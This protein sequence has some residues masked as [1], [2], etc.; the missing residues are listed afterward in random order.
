MTA[1]NYATRAFTVIDDV[2]G[3]RAI[4]KGDDVTK[5]KPALADNQLE[6]YRLCGLIGERPAE[7]PKAAAAA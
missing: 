5:L 6:D 2:N 1:K 3:E 4:A 7:E